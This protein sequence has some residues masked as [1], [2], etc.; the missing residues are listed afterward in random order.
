VVDLGEMKIVDSGYKKLKQGI[1]DMAV[2]PD[3]SNTVLVVQ[4][5]GFIEFVNPVAN[6]VLVGGVQLPSNSIFQICATK[7][8]NI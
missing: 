1:Y 4:H 6:E 2:I 3:N 5:F 8:P 7:S